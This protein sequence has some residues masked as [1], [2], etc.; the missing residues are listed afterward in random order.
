MPMVKAIAAPAPSGAV[1]RII[2]ITPKSILLVVSINSMMGRAYSAFRRARANPRRTEMSNTWRM[3]P[4]VKALKSVLG[5]IFS[6]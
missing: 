6:R 2:R 5:I 3:S 4:S 1:K